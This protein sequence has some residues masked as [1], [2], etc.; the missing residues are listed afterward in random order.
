MFIEASI[1]KELTADGYTVGLPVN[2]DQFMLASGIESEA[3]TY[4]LLVYTYVQRLPGPPHV[5]VRSALGCTLDAIFSKSVAMGS[6][7]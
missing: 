1:V 7:Q 5:Y 4:R 2:L 3:A 6:T